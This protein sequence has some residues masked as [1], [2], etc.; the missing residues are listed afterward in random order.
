MNKGLISTDPMLAKAI[1]FANRIY[2]QQ[3]KENTMEISQENTK[4]IFLETKYSYLWEQAKTFLKPIKDKKSILFDSS[5]NLR[6]PK[7]WYQD[8]TDDDNS[9]WERYV[10]LLLRKGWNNAVNDIRTSTRDLIDRIPDPNGEKM[11]VYGMVVGRVQSGK[12]AN[13]TG[14]IARAVDS[15]YNLIIVLSGTVNNLRNQTQIRLLREL[16]GHKKHPKGHHVGKPN[17]QDKEF[18][19][20]TQEGEQDFGRP[21]TTFL[22]SKRPMLAV[23]KK[24]VDIMEKLYRWLSDTTNKQREN[25]KLLLI[26]DECDYGSINTNRIRP[27]TEDLRLSEEDR[28]E[29][30]EEDKKASKTN[31]YVRGILNLFST[32]AYLGYTATPYANVMIDPNPDQAEFDFESGEGPV[33]LG[34]TLYPRNFIKLLKSPDEYIGLEEIFSDTNEKYLRTVEENEARNIRQGIFER[35]KFPKS[36]EKS[37]YDYI[38]SGTIK[39]NNLNP[40]KWSKTHHTMMV[41]ISKSVK[42]MRPLAKLIDSRIK[43]WKEIIWD[44]YDSDFEL[45]KK[46]LRDS[47]NSYDGNRDF[48]IDLVRDFIEEIQDTRLVNSENDEGVKK[49]ELDPDL[50]FEQ[51][52]VIGVIIGGDLLSR[53][54]TVE[55]LTISYFLRRAGTYDSAIQMCRWNGVRTKSE[56]DLIR[57]YMENEMKEDYY[58]L[59]RVETDLRLDIEYG[60]TNAMTPSDYAIRVLIHK[61]NYDLEKGGKRKIMTPTNRKKMTSVIKVDRGIHNTIQQTRGFFL[62]NTELMKRNADITKKFLDEINL[63]P[64][65]IQENNTGHY[66]AKRV[67]FSKVWNLIEHLQFPEGGFN[68]LGI[69]GYFR[70]MHQEFPVNLENWSV[71]LIGSGDGEIFVLNNNVKIKMPTRK[72]NSPLGIRELATDR[73]LSL[74]LENYPEGLINE[75]NQFSRLL[76]QKK[77]TYNQPLLIIYL[78]DPNYDVNEYPFFSDIDNSPPEC[79]VAPVVV[80]PNLNLNDEQLKELIAYYRLENLPGSG[81]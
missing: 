52:S 26:D 19:L 78:L 39:K 16:T 72:K 54:L 45:L 7:P 70:Y 15:G 57:I 65:I 28:Y 50:N 23:I 9:Y 63:K 49:D 21:D 13:F 33:S 10:D 66:L 53:G 58:H 11:D 36:L 71:V 46:E 44:H 25:I 75:K 14:L 27:K 56:K 41:H 37:L 55:G 30:S 43:Y 64:I 40:E 77:R 20:L 60:H 38:I 81:R 35:D 31:S 32:R 51:S 22:Y 2:I 59:K 17:D 18:L 24:N 34:D 73:H 6:Q 61:V 74:D 62:E 47:W 68:H 79:I 8:P 42:I 29:E 69:L 1:T 12:T 67:S 4:K 5:E 76:M 80:I 3:M 48:D